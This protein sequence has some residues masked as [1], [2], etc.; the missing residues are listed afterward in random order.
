[1]IFGIENPND[2]M[3]IDIFNYCVLMAKAYIVQC[4]NTEQEIS[5]YEYL[6][7]VK[8]KLDIE[9]LYYRIE[10]TDAKILHKWTLLYE[11]I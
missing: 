11:V 10:K 8:K 7:Y 4:R 3:Y 5:L 9:M 1:M 6:R 2:D